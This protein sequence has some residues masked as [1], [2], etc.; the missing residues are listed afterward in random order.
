MQ[1]LD[2]NF[3][4]LYTSTASAFLVW[5]QNRFTAIIIY[6]II[7]ILTN[8]LAAQKLQISQVTRTIDSFTYSSLLITEL[9]LFSAPKFDKLLN[10]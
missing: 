1:T 10:N 5:T 7:I 9:S 8:D 4:D 6:H 3:R 2:C